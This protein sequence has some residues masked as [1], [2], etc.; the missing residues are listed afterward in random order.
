M[1]AFWQQ[2]SSL[3]FSRADEK[4]MDCIKGGLIGVLWLGKPFIH[5]RGF[6]QQAA[7]LKK[8]SW[9]AY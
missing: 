3:R 1:L 5:D 4:W 6:L 7:A 8:V 9:K 2:S